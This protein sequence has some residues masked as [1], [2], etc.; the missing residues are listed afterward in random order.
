M[1]GYL[2]RIPS[3]PRRSPAQGQTLA[4]HSSAAAATGRTRLLHLHRIARAHLY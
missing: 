1:P 4:R 3:L 2:L